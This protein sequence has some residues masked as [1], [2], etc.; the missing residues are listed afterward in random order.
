MARIGVVVLGASLTMMAGCRH[1]EQSPIVKS[2]Q[3]AGGGDASNSTPDGIVQFLAKHDDLRLKLTPLCKQRQSNAPSDWSST[4]E[5]KIC[6]GNDSANFFG[7]TKI[8]SDGVKF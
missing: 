6:A 4:D 3:D 8:K 5:G 7:K 1:V 2:F